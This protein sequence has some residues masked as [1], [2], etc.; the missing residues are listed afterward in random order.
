[1]T[2]RFLDDDGT[3]DLKKL[4]SDL[5][6]SLPKYAQPIF[7]RVVR[8]PLDLTGTYKLQKQVLK[9][10][11]YSNAGDDAIFFRG[12]RDAEFARFSKEDIGHLLARLKTSKL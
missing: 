3:L 12:P 1:M 11:G 4:A 10:E 6:K 2:L 7:V 9:R 5:D 8:S